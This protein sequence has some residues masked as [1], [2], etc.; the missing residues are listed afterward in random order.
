LGRRQAR[1]LSRQSTGDD[2]GL[3]HG[4]PPAQDGNPRRHHRLPEG[5]ELNG[6]A[7]SF[8]DPRVRRGEVAGLLRTRVRAG[9]RRS[10]QVCGFRADLPASSLLAVPSALLADGA[11]EKKLT[12]TQ[13]QYDADKDGKLSE[14]EKAAA[15]EGAK[16]KAKATR[17]ANLDKY[18]ANGDGKLDAEE[19]AAKKAAEQAAKEAR[20]AE[21]EAKK[22]EKKAAKEAAKSK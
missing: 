5:A 13:Q 11:G 22:A 15:K 8:D 7:C 21:R 9:S 20:K 19:R 1:C 18:D 2:S 16:A 17:D 10:S 14:E 6:K 12:K 4:L 3:Q